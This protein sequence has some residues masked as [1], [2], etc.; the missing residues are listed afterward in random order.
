MAKIPRPSRRT[1]AYGLA[2]IVPGLMLGYQLLLKRPIG[3]PPPLMLFLAPVLLCGYLAGLGPAI[4][5]TVVSALLL[6]WPTLEQLHALDIHNESHRLRWLMLVATGLLAGLLTENLH[7]ARRRAEASD[8]RSRVL[9]EYSPIAYLALDEA[10]RCLAANPAVCQLLGHR[11]EELIGTPLEHYAPPG[12]PMADSLRRLLSDG[13]LA[14]TET[15]LLR[16]DGSTVTTLLKGRVQRGPSGEF[17]RSHC[18]LHDITE[19]KILENQLRDRQQLLDAIVDNS[20]YCVFVKDH[21]GRYRLANRNLQSLLNRSEQD[22]LGLTDFDFFPEDIARA[23]R[24]ADA[25]VLARRTPQTLEEHATIDGRTRTYRSHK[26]PVLDAAGNAVLLACMALDI[27][28]EKELE[29]QRDLL[30][31]VVENSTDFVGICTPDMKPFYLNDAGRRMVGLDSM[32]EVLQT[33]VMDYFWPEDRAHIESEAV[34]ALLREG[35]WCGEVRF[36]HFKTGEPIHTLWNAFVIRNAKGAPVAWVTNSPD[37]TPLKR[38]EAE[39]V[40]LGKQLKTVFVTAPIGL[41]IAEDPDGHTIRGNPALER[42]VG[43]PPGGELSQ[44]APKRTGYRVL[45]GDAEADVDTLPMQRACRGETVSG[46]LLEI[47][48][49]DRGRITVQASAAPLLDADGRLCGAV[50]AFVDITAEIQ[51][52]QELERSHQQLEQLVEQ[53][54]RALQSALAEVERSEERYRSFFSKTTFAMLIIDP[55]DGAIVEANGAACAFYGY[56]ADTLRTM[57]VVDLNELP[58]AQLSREMARIT[59]TPQTLFHVRNRLASGEVRD[60]EVYTG[61]IEL[62]GR[63]LLYSIIH[64]ISERKRVERAARESE[65][66]VKTLGDNLPDGALYQLVMPVDGGR[67]FS[68]VSDSLQRLTGI[69][70]AEAME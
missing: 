57:R 15:A 31:A 37:L 30:A 40:R 50:G 58:A 35:R 25:E 20:P 45:Q 56:P 19:R 67:R 44:R 1:L 64:D 22:I 14:A 17:V 5:A 43:V 52:K 27:D 60:V 36:R 65:A 39:A 8:A 48:R 3:E 49:A 38:I 24:A 4:A 33:R 23:L 26:F 62:Q 54:T 41:S 9:F 61:P 42:M 32:A 11:E 63:T 16:R 34:P 53:R 29:R 66:R 46:E 18:V 69:S 55:E 21:E 13:R 10:G 70:A 68:H 12:S 51:A 6:S 28:E 2:L 7:Q 47:E 59:A